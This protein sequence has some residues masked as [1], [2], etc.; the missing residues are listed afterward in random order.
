MKPIDVLGFGPKRTVVQVGE[1]YCITVT[2]PT[3]T[4]LKARSV[5]LNADQWLRYQAWLGGRLIQ[6]AL[7]DLSDDDRE[8]LITGIGP[9]DFAKLYE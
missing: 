4:K 2:P 5:T 6:D 7:P 9:E 8:I 3:A 1:N